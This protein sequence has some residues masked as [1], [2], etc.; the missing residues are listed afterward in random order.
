MGFNVSLPQVAPVRVWGGVLNP[1]S[2]LQDRQIL[3]HTAVC[4]LPALVKSVNDEG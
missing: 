4:L 3:L 1:C 2:Q